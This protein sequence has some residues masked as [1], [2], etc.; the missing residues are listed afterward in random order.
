ME[1]KIETKKTTNHRGQQCRIITKITGVAPV[2]NLHHTY[3][4]LS[5]NHPSVPA[6]AILLCPDG[7][8]RWQYKIMRRRQAFGGMISESVI[9]L[10][11]NITECEFQAILTEVNDATNYF[12]A[13]NEYLSESGE[14]V[15]KAPRQRGAVWEGAETIEVGHGD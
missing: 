11:K 10:R 9:P 6:V 5:Y 14:T 15:L 4:S 2:Q 7:T 12:H 1:I 13:V 8:H 3:A